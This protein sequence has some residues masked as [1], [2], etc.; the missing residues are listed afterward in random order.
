MLKRLYEWTLAKAAHPL[1]ERWLAAIAF[2]ESSVFP[3]PPDVVLAPMCLARPDRAMRYG[4]ICTAGSTV[5]AG[6]GW[7]IGALLF[8]TVGRWVLALYN[9]EAEFAD[10][11]ARFNDEG[12]L[13]VMLAGFT[14]IPFKVVTIASGAT[15]LSIYVLLVASVISRGARFF[16][17]AGLL[18]LFGEPMKRVI[19]RHFGL[20]TFAVA[21]L[22][23]GGFAA[24][25]WLV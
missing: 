7:I 5:G 16:L 3:I 14:P 17:V 25:R 24:L 1:A 4:G 21:A 23:V 15:G 13:I 10:I 20:I 19:D 12:W 11:A 18:K 8:E 6:L 9:V 22:L 2:V